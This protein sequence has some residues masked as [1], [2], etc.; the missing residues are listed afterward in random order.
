MTPQGIIGVLTLIVILAIITTIV[1]RRNSA[2][3]INALG[4]FFSG[5]IRVA[6]GR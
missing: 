2:T 6:M 4:S 5:S 3:I 1:S